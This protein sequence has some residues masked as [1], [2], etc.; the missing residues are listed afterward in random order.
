MGVV[1]YF[2]YNLISGMLGNGF[3]YDAISL[4]VSII[5]GA[6]V[7]GILVIVLKVEEI[8][9]IT[10]MINKKIANKIE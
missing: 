1:T 9:I 2:G 3:V 6:I 5:F 8:S 7:Y 4:F 10:D